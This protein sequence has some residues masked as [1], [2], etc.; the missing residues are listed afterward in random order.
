VVTAEL[1]QKGL[2]SGRR[3]PFFSFSIIESEDVVKSSQGSL[4][5]AEVCA[6][7]K[8]F[9]FATS[10][11]I[12]IYGEEFEVLSDPFPSAEGIALNVR[13]QKTAEIRVLQL[14]S[15]ITQRVNDRTRAA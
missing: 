15:T 6:R 13:S 8:Q 2:N 1:S 12:R 14:P 4:S 5:N 11:K 10:Q 7:I 9:G 3:T